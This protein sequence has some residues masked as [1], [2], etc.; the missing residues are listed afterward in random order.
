MPPLPD[1]QIIDI[2]RP[3]S[4]DT[5]CW[6]G[7]TP[8]AFQLEWKISDGA[9]VNVGSVRTSVHTATHCDASFHFDNHGM[10]VDQLSLGVFC[11]PAWVI[12]VRGVQRWGSRLDAIDFSETPRVL[13]RT[14]GWPET[15]R[16]PDAIP[17]MEPELPARLVARGV[18]LIGVDLP[19]VDPLDSKTLDI[20]HAL[21]RAG[22]VILEG[23]W[24]EEVP[25]GRYDLAALPLKIVGADGSPVRAALRPIQRWSTQ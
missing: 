11:G 15:T 9:S 16:F 24:L 18:V 4:G 2:S 22:I 19:S 21:G 5:A 13:F 20:H 14:G 12:D 8:F 3:L 1:S 10:P 7:D 6:P 25:E 23:L 17:V